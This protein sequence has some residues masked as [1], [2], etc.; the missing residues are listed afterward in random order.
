MEVCVGLFGVCGRSKWRDAFIDAYRKEG[1]AFFNPNVPDWKPENAVVE[2]KHL[3]ED[4]VVLFPVTSE[5]YATGSLAETGFSLLN[6]IKLDDRRDF[7]TF[8]E[9]RL[10]DDLM[11]D[12]PT[13]AKESLRARALVKEHLKR[14]RLSNLY[15][16]DS[17][18]DMLAVSIRLYRLAEARAGLEGFRRPIG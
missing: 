1:I 5:T 11:A 7:V 6:A 14:L 4:A 15:Y 13:M 10:D 9:Q 8:I 3:S 12:N 17:L 16:V 2:A 18:Q